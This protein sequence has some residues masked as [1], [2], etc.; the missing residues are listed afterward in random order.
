MFLMFAWVSREIRPGFLQTKR[1]ELRKDLTTSL[2]ISKPQYLL[3]SAYQTKKESRTC[4][5]SYVFLSKT[6]G[7]VSGC[8]TP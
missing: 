7:D 3:C 1:R 5:P 2:F 4:L 8:Q 6:N